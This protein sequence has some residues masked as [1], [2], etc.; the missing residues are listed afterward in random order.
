MWNYIFL[1]PTVAAEREVEHGFEFEFEPEK[2]GPLASKMNNIK[3]EGR[4]INIHT[5]FT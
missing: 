2:R 4:R 1:N 3:R 5:P